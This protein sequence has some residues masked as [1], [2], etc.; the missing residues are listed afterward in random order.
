MSLYAYNIILTV[1]VSVAVIGGIIVY[2][3]LLDRHLRNLQRTIM[4][5]IERL[6]VTIAQRSAFPEGASGDQFEQIADAIA[7]RVVH[8]V[9]HNEENSDLGPL[10]EQAE[11]ETEEGEKPSSVTQP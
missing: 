4:L 8:N 3:V 11:P 1:I 6:R 10:A 9:A 2:F 7:E 5:E